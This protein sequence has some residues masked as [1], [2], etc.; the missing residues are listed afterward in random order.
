MLLGIIYKYVINVMVM[1]K[2][3]REKVVAGLSV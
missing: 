1:G 3:L 2:H